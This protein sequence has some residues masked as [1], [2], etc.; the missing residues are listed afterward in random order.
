MSQ[1]VRVSAPK[2]VGQPLSEHKHDTRLSNQYH[3]NDAPARQSTG[4]IPS[5][6]LDSLDSAIWLSCRFAPVGTGYAGTSRATVCR[7]L[8]P[9][10]A[11]E[12]GSPGA[13]W[14]I[15]SRHGNLEVDSMRGTHMTDWTVTNMLLIYTGVVLLVWVVMDLVRRW[16]FW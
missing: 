14:S 7:Q 16:W 2:T 5:F 6:A 15:D 9:S 10:R 3:H 13:F 8:T 11:S 4:P 1:D 12:S